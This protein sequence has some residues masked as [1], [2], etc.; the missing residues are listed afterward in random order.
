MFGFFKRQLEKQNILINKAKEKDLLQLQD[1]AVMTF[2][3][4]YFDYI[5]TRTESEIEEELLQLYSMNKLKDWITNSEFYCLVV[6]DQSCSNKI[7][8]YS[9]LFLDS[10]Q[11]KLSKIYLLNTYQGKGIG[12]VLL[13]ANYDRLRLSPEIEQ[14]RLDVWDSNQSAKKFYNRMGLFETGNKVLYQESASLYPF[15]D[16]VF[17]RDRVNYIS[18]YDFL[19]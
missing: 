1:V 16:D 14:L 5:K 3:E 19:R 13:E 10:P 9:L 4:T 17:Q 11:A 18:T 12:R 15:Y 7:V 2:R 8:G 6:R